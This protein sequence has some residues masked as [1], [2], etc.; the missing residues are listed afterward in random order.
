MI[1]FCFVFA[2]K[3]SWAGQAKPDV[4]CKILDVF[5]FMLCKTLRNVAVLYSVKTKRI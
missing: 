1:G 5:I 2:G 3:G 4:R